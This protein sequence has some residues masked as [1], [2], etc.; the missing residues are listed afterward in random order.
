MRSGRKGLK[1][2]EEQIDNLASRIRNLIEG[3]Q[4]EISDQET[5]KTIVYRKKDGILW[6]IGET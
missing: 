6:K 2:I 5:G 3:D 4:V 1:M